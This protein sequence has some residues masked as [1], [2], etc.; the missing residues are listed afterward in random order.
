MDSGPPARVAW[1]DLR[2]STLRPVVASADGRCR[3]GTWLP[4]GASCFTFREVPEILSTIVDSQQFCG[5]ACA[6]AFLLESV[7]FLDA[8]AP[9]AALKDLDATRVALRF[10]IALLVLEG[11]DPGPRGAH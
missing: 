4:A 9:L 5:I 1:T 2:L 8:A 11:E 10:Q 7:E 6:R 3:C